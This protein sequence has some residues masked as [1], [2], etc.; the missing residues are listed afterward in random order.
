MWYCICKYVLSSLFTLLVPSTLWRETLFIKFLK[1]KS[2]K[3]CFQWQLLLSFAQCFRSY[4]HACVPSLLM[5]NTF[6]REECI[7]SSPLCMA[8]NK[9]TNHSKKRQWLTQKKTITWT[10]N[11][12]EKWVYL[13]LAITQERQWGLMRPK[14]RDNEHLDLR[15]L[16]LRSYKERSHSLGDA[17]VC[18]F[19]HSKS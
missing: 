11:L 16:M 5:C 8:K 3:S 19:G 7:K 4:K 14:G 13:T 10:L 6:V 9:D 2:S 12:W 17:R 18:Y 1:I 15:E